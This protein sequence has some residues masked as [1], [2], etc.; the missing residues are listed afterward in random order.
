M[1]TLEILISASILTKGQNRNVEINTVN[2]LSVI[3]TEVCK[4]WAWQAQTGGS[5]HITH[6]QR[7]WAPLKPGLWIIGDSDSIISEL[8]LFS[9]PWQ[10]I[11]RQL[12]LSM[13]VLWSQIWSENMLNLSQFT[14]KAVLHTFMEG[15]HTLQSISAQNP[16]V[17]SV[18]R[19]KNLVKKYFGYL[20]NISY[21]IRM[22]KD[23][24]GCAWESFS[25]CA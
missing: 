1:F 22:C 23:I 2:V 3:S 18:I 5:T 14:R 12:R 10:W 21:F 15:S 8:V 13:L 17:T 25:W 11:C 24:G 16:L 7:S 9:F 4:P 6:S 19:P 20:N